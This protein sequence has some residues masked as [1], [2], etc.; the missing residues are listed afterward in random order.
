MGSSPAWAIL[1]GVPQENIDIVLRSVAA[2][3]EGGIEATA[4]FLHPEVEFQEP[5]EQPAPR[6]THGVEEGQSAYSAFDEAWEEHQTEV[7]EIRE[8]G[9]DEVLLFTIEHFRG[10][11]GM[12]LD[13]PCTT[14]VT[15]RDGKITRFRPFWDR[16]QALA[17]AGLSTD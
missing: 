8:L 7:E 4:E 11:D 1:E 17:A 12:A 16:E 5:P 3:N 13:Q 9:E 6:I 2:L 15:L 10:R 14:I